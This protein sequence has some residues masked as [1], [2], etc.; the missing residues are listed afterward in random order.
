MSVASLGSCMTTLYD[1]GFYGGVTMKKKDF[2]ITFRPTDYTRRLLSKAGLI[3]Y[4]NGQV[5]NRG[6]LSFL[7]NSL[8]IERFAYLGSEKM[9]MLCKLTELQDKRDKIQDEILFV[10]D[11]IKQAREKEGIM[12]KAEDCYIVNLEQE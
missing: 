2:R 7:M 5:V 10:A 4:Q 12:K 3:K 1:I 9:K 8:L 11:Q 6:S